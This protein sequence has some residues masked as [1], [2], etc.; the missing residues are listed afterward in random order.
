MA[1]DPLS[2]RHHF[3]SKGYQRN[4]AGPD[5]RV[6]VLDCRSG[7]IL[8]AG[9]PVKSNFAAEGYNSFVGVDGSSSNALER[10]WC[11]LERSTLDQVRRVG[12]TR[13]TGEQRSAIVTLFAM[14]L[15]RSPSFHE[16]HQ[17]IVER[18][19]AERV[20]A[21]ADRPEVLVQFRAEVSPTAAEGDL[22]AY[23]LGLYDEMGAGNR[24][25]VDSMVS[26]FNAIAER[27]SRLH[28]QVIEIDEQIS[29]GFALGDVPVVH[30]DTRTGRY[31]FRDELAV[32]DA[33][34]VVGPLTRR[35]AVALSESRDPLVQVT[36]KRLLH[37]INAVF[38]RAAAAEVACHPDDA[39]EVR[40]VIGNL[41]RLPVGR[42]R[43]PSGPRRL[44]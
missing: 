3:V 38:V 25:H 41:W 32:G 17:K 44:V 42:L 13:V 35:L 37:T 18:V 6:A 15:V 2:E 27:F 5:H 4:F 23:V 29:D 8:H 16:F 11:D 36:T 40:R 1:V 20:P 21:L 31:G 14:H 43:Q 33:D 30:A 24:R 12:S 22:L 19:G 10:I 39:R 7:A 26:Q 28:V 34:L 9:R